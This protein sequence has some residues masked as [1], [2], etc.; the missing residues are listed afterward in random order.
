MALTRVPRESLCVQA[1][2]IAIAHHV[3][4]RRRRKVG[5]KHEDRRV[6]VYLE[7]IE[8]CAQ[9]A[10]AVDVCIIFPL[11][12]HELQRVVEQVAGDDGPLTL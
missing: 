12:V 10:L 4:R 3:P 9:C 1:I 11:G 7:K 6:R 2:D 8:T 5:S